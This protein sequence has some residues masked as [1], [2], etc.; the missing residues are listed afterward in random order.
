MRLIGLAG[1]MGVGKT[2]A[3]H[4]LQDTQSLPVHVVK[5]AQALYDM[6]EFI[7]RRIQ[8]VHKRPD[9]F[10][11]DRMLLQWL[12]T[13]WGREHISETLWVDLWKAQ[14]EEI[15]EQNSRCI[16]VSDDV[17]FDNEAHMITSMGGK[18]IKLESAHATKRIDTTNG[19][20]NHLSE[21]GIDSKYISHVIKND[22]SRKD[23]K[24]SLC[25]VYNNVAYE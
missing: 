5:F 21:N 10:Q 13:E 4:V 24:D 16:I 25:A 2:T 17:R 9:S 11:K 1:G 7:Y 3:I 20:V 19:I 23:F 14:V 8:S 12:G 6:Q 15:L 18:I 22:G